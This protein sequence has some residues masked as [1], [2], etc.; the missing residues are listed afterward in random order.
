MFRA[1]HDYRMFVDKRT[2]AGELFG[3]LGVVTGH[4]VRLPDENNG[5]TSAS[6]VFEVWKILSEG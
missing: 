5:F 3:T 2:F 4:A 6:R 1:S